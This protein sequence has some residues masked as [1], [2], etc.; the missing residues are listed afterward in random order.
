MDIRK[1]IGDENEKPLDTLPADGGF[2]GILRTIACVGDSLASGEFE[3]KKKG[4]DEK[5]FLDRYDYSWGQFMARQAGCTVYNFSRG[6]MTAKVYMQEFANA[7]GYWKPSYAANAYVIALGVNDILNRGWE[8]GTVEDICLEDYRKNADSFAGWYAAIIQR[9][10]E[11]VPEAK[12]FLVTMPRTEQVST[13]ERSFKA[14]RHREL[15][16]EMAAMFT[17]TYVVDLREYGPIYD[18]QF[19]TMFY[20]KYGH[21]NP[22]GYLV[23]ARLI[24]AYIDYIIRHNFVDFREVGLMGFDYD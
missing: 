19:R 15:L 3:V 22:S 1:I 6:G 5:V 9:Y 11:I 21:M 10:K 4:T 7:N 2:V 18:E 16:H 20:G 14:D 13:T 8:I 12:F 24:N 23:T 17:N